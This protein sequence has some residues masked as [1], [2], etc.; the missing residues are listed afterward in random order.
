MAA[1]SK[2]VRMEVRNLGCIGPAGLE[3]ALDNI[4]CIVGRNNVGKSTVL[5]AY[6]LAQGNKEV[7][8]DD[9]C[10]FEEGLL[11]EVVLDV[12]IPDGIGNVG[13]QWKFE[14]DGLKIVRSRWQWRSPNAKPVRQTWDPEANDNKGD[15]GE[16]ER[17]G[18]LDSVF[19]ARLPKPLRIDSL[20]DADKEHEELLKLITDPVAKELESLSRDPD[21]DLAKAMGAVV[22][23]A[24]KPVTTFKELI[25]EA[26]AEIKTRVKGVFPGLDLRIQVDMQPPKWEPSKQLLAGSSLRV[27]DSGVETK[28]QQQGSGSRRA[29]FW[30]I[31]QVRSQLVRQ[32]QAKERT[33]KE[34]ASLLQKIEKAQGKKKPDAE[35]IDSLKSRLSALE[36]NAD[37]EDIALP[38]HILLIDEP[39]NALHPMAI[40]SAQQHLYELARDEDWQVMLTTH[41]PYFINPL[42]DHATIV[43]IERDGKQSTPRTYRAYNA[44][45]SEEEKE[46]LRALL[47]IDPS[48]CEMFFGSYPIVVEGDTEQAAFIASVL[49]QKD[50]LGEQ[51]TMVRAR[52][53]A[54]IEPL[55]RLLTHFRVP[56]GVLHDADSPF[57]RDGAGNG[58]WTE[59]GKIAAAVKAA[60]EAGLPVRHRISIPDF[61]RRIGGEEESKDKPLLAYRRVKND[62]SLLEMISSL[63]AELKEH[64]DH[65]P[66][67]IEEIA[68]AGGDV[69]GALRI[70]VEAWAAVNAP[71]DIRFFGKDS[72]NQEKKLELEMIQ[73]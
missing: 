35:E 11:P 55:I 69:L 16:G 9:C 36:S 54:L 62:K 25:D 23:E 49:E 6:E 46:N 14:V 33:E 32:R 1:R 42:Q 30:S 73:Q 59:N 72:K 63:I 56:F 24:L 45:F 68:G 40:R 18:G 47:Q 43:R 64:A 28:L 26:A 12:H 57:R 20:Q 51:V 4:V 58:S 48:L 3:I 61:E 19:S 50:P 65:D 52:G 41:S 17:A 66:F 70:Q 71:L 44:S 29:M 67:P 22:S 37:P 34:R 2:L 5:R 7:G 31:L 15:W 60:R 38:G 10:K 39:E 27:L 53:K 13:S 21:S 8:P